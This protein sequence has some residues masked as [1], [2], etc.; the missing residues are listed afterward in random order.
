[1]QKEILG[2]LFKS[3]NDKNPGFLRMININN[4]EN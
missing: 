2:F 3:F 1:M 4:I